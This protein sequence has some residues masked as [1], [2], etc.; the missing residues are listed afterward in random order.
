MTDAGALDVLRVI[1]TAQGETPGRDYNALAAAAHD[2]QL[3]PGLIVKLASLDHIIE[4]K[5]WAD[6]PKDHEALDE[7]IN[8]QRSN[9]HPD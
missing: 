4:S 3:L 7:L 2:H 5:Q 1:P 8:L 6:R 9:Q